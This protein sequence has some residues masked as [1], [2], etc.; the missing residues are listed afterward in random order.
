MKK[1]MYVALLVCS[2]LLIFVHEEVS[3]S[4]DVKATPNLQ[5]LHVNDEPFEVW[6]YVING[7]NYFQLRELAQIARNHSVRFDVSWDQKNS[8]IEVVKNKKYPIDFYTYMKDTPFSSRYTLSKIKLNN[9]IHT[10]NSYVIDNYTYFQLRELGELLKFDVSYDNKTGNAL[11]KS[12]PLKGEHVVQYTDGYNDFFVYNVKQP[13]YPRWASPIRQFILENPNGTISTI[14]ANE[15]IIVRTY[16]DN[17]QVIGEKKLRMELPI[18]GTFFSGKQY[19]Y[20]S[21]GVNNREEANKEIIRIVQYDK[22]FNRINSVSIYGDEATTTVP[23][24]ASSGGRMAEEG[25][26]LIYYTSRERYT[27]EDGLNHQSNMTIEID[28]KKMEKINN[29]TPSR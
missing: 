5:K 22:Q 4:N 10:M 13:Y 17:Y 15:Q 21:Y 20:I 6:T 18:F 16:D 23:F 19:N 7:H 9:T 28:T 26:R 8:I 1:I 14:E 2:I 12:E 25:D 11:I 3:A 27:S 24:D 29:I